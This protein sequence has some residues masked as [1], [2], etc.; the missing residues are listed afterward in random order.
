MTRQNAA[1]TQESHI[2]QKMI[3]QERGKEEPSPQYNSHGQWCGWQDWNDNCG[4]EDR[5]SS[6]NRVWTIIGEPATSQ[7]E[8][9]G[10]TTMTTTHRD[11]QTG[12][13]TQNREEDNTTKRA[14][15]QTNTEIRGPDAE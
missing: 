14:E 11:G 6:Q 9:H 2:T 15:Q 5:Y 10:N 3:T 7:G 8:C 1:A 13:T 12:A 4:V